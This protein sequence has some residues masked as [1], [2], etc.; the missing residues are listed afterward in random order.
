MNKAITIGI[1]LTI[2]VSIVLSI[3]ILEYYPESVTPVKTP[4]PGNIN[5]IPELEIPQG[6]NLTIDL[7]E[8]FQISGN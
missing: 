5:E 8:D 1:P 4:E 7:T 2:I 3:T 6:K